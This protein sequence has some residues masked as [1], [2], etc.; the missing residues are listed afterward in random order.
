MR[1]HSRFAGWVDGRL[2]IIR[3]QSD[4][5]PL[6]STAA[7]V[8]L[9]LTAG[10]ADASGLLQMAAGPGD[11]A[12]NGSAVAE[13]LSPSGALFANPAGLAAFAETTLSGSVGVGLG[14]ERITVNGDYDNMNDVTAMI[15]DAA[16]SVAGANGWRYAMGVYGSV[17]IS[18]DFPGD[19]EAGLASDYLSESSIAAIPFAVAKRVNEKLWLG[20][21]LSPMIGYLRNRYRAS[22]IPFSYK[23]IG[24]GIQGMVGATWKPDNRW[25]FG[26]GIRTPGRVWMDG[27]DEDPSGGRQDVDLE[28]KL[29]TQVLGGIERQAT[30]NLRL[31]LSLRWTDSST[32]GESRT[33]F[34]AM[35]QARPAFV[36]DA[37]DEWRGA[38]GLRYQWTQSVELRSGLAYSTRIVGTSGVSPL[39]FD[40]NHV[41]ISI[42]TAYT[43]SL[44]TFEFMAG[45][46]PFEERK[47]HEDEALI[48]PGEY[49]SGG[50][51]FMFGVQ[52]RL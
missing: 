2:R 51:M 39:L 26:L 38:L 28:V 52:R 33:D 8:L 23:L 22:D 29:P 40:N 19:P 42:G 12:I 45:F 24:P 16:I 1:A 14:H 18:Y 43:R 30:E 49:Q 6:A 4:V 9:L 25:S 10:A 36:P 20:A 27:S 17:G 13:P 7:L 34:S 32:F 44:W 47:V 50:G 35:P 37:K 48:V 3:M 15:P 21:E 5:V 31:L 46:I 41:A 11:M